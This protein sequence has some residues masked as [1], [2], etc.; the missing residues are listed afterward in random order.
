M[1]AV[2]TRLKWRLMILAADFLK[3][4]SDGITAQ[5]LAWILATTLTG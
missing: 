3:V 1:E 5:D 4:G 2:L